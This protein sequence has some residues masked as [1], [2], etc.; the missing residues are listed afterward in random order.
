[1][2][3]YE[4]YKYN[5]QKIV[6]IIKYKSILKLLTLVVRKKY[7]FLIINCDKIELYITSSYY[8]YECSL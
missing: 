3:Q 4:F 1:M 8:Y 6:M 5:T 7:F 2:S